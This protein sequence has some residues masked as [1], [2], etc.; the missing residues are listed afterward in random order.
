VRE[1]ALGAGALAFLRKPFNDELLAQTL[2]AALKRG[3]SR[4]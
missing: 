4:N 2:R 1:K 3:A